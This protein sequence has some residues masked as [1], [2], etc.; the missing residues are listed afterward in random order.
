MKLEGLTEEIAIELS[1]NTYSKEYVLE[2]ITHLVELA[3]VK[4]KLDY[5]QAIMPKYDLIGN[6]IT[7][8]EQ[9]ES[10]KFHLLNPEE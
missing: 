1:E 5:L 4:G 3:K 10:C 9:I 8:P 2:R 6:H 7:E